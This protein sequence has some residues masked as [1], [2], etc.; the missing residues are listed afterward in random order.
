MQPT[1]DASEQVRADPSRSLHAPKH[2][3]AAGGHVAVV[4]RHPRSIVVESAGNAAEVVGE[5]DP[6]EPPDGR[7]GRPREVRAGPDR[8]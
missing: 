4:E 6:E 2:H 5:L 1:L 3:A 8:P 7:L